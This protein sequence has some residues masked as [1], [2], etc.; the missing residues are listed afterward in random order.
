MISQ[1]FAKDAMKLANFVRM[2]VHV[3]PFV[4][5]DIFFIEKQGCAPLANLARFMTRLAKNALLALIIAW[6]AKM[7]R[8]VFGVKTALLSGKGSA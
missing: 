6:S 8:N 7:I 4:R 2:G 3:S 5:R 1:A